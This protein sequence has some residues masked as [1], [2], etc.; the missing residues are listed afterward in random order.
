MG[1]KVGLQLFSVRDF[2]LFSAK[3]RVKTLT[4]TRRV[5]PDGCDP[6]G[7]IRDPD[8]YLAPV[9]WGAGDGE[10]AIERFNAVDH[11]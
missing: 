11:V 1:T 9:S 8:P 6:T 3:P 4:S 10:F 5:A 2:A 7:S